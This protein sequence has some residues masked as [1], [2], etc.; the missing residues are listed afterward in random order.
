MLKRLRRF[1]LFINLKKYK[2]FIKEIEFLEF[3]ILTQ[4]LGR[5]NRFI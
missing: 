2:F 3:I 4:G 1:R 5:N